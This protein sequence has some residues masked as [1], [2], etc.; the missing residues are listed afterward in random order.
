[1]SSNQYADTDQPFATN[2]TVE[3]GAIMGWISMQTR[4]FEANQNKPAFNKP[5]YS[6]TA[7]DFAEAYAA[8]YEQ[9]DRCN[10][11]FGKMTF[12][13]T[14]PIGIRSN[15]GIRYAGGVAAVAFKAGYNARVNA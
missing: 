3:E 13:N 9:A 12:R 1:M 4:V 8:G 10:Q 11:V 5:M 2:A 14:N 6:Q 7:E 15:T